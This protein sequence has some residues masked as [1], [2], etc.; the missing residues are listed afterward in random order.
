[1]MGDESTLSAEVLDRFR[2]LIQKESGIFIGEQK[3]YLLVSKLSRFLRVSG[4]S[5]PQALL[6]EL[7]LGN[8]DLL[9]GLINAITTNHTFFFRESNHLKILRRDIQVKGLNKPLIWVAA[10]STG[11]EV[12]SIIIELLEAGIVNFLVVASDINR[13]VLL[14]MKQGVYHPQ[15]VREVPPDLLFKYFDR[16]PE[17]NYRVKEFLK[18]Y[19]VAKKLNLLDSFRFQAKFDY[20]FCRNVLIYFDKPTQQ[21]VIDNLLDNLS[22]LGYL[23]IGHSETLMHLSDRA[24]SVFTSVYNKKL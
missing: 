22:D 18:S 1:M 9:E 24:E 4:F 5:E 2:D 19:L 12:Y 10:A 6:D 17:G 23:F 21:R 15:R 8:Q 13:E 20:I 3:D 7:A 11:E 16:T 14:H